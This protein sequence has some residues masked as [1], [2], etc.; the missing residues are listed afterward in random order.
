MTTDGGAARPGIGWFERFG[1]SERTLREELSAAM[2]RGGDFADLFFQ[3]RVETDLALEDGAVNRGFA[4][5]ELGVGVRVVK[6]DQTGY[7]YTEDLSLPAILAAARTA[8]A[9]ADGASR[10]APVRMHLAS[11]PGGRYPSLAPGEGEGAAARLPVLEAV[12]ARLLAADPS[13]RKVNVHL[14]DETSAV[15]IA[16]SSGRVVEDMQPMALL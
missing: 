12:N 5:I 10:D 9:I 7:G 2:S 6:G 14:H 8:A 11:R 4:S 15:L 13:V 16:D 3:H 1:V